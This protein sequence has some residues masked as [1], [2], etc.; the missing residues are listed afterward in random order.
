M[1]KLFVPFNVLLCI[2]FINLKAS[3]VAIDLPHRHFLPEEQVA[4]DREPGPYSLTIPVAPTLWHQ[5]PC[6]IHPEGHST[7]TS[8]RY[9][10]NLLTGVS[11]F[12]FKGYVRKLTAGSPFGHKKNRCAIFFNQGECES[13]GPEFGLF[14]PDD[15]SSAFFYAST[16]RNLKSGG[17]TKKKKEKWWQWPKNYAED[18]CNKENSPE[19]AAACRVI[20]NFFQ[21]ASAYRYWNVRIVE[22]GDFLLEVIDP[23][24]LQTSS[25]QLK[26][27]AWFPNLYR[28]SGYITISAKKQSDRGMLLPA[29]VMRVDE[30][31]I[32]KE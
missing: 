27:P 1:H 26:K 23:D 19:N 11:G 21:D 10:S 20:K 25:Y 30:V 28:A 7:V 29:T 8:K 4:A 31:K 9:V 17:K 18:S 14:F 3:W 5:T 24:S 32:W 15:T 12:S 6:S 2:F 22:S 16:E 13:S